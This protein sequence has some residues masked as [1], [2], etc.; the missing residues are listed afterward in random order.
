MWPSFGNKVRRCRQDVAYPYWAFQHLRVANGR[1]SPL[2]PAVLD[3]QM[4]DGLRMARTSNGA[5]KAE[6]RVVEGAHEAHQVTRSLNLENPRQPWSGAKP[7]N[8]TQALVPLSA[9]CR[10]DSNDR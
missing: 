3:S 6:L 7:L 1:I 9:P 5:E 10:W 2:F 4:A 8:H